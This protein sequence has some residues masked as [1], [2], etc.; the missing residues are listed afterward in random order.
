MDDDLK[1][2][3]F[4]YPS[5]YRNHAVNKFAFENIVGLQTK[6]IKFLD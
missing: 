1:G 5:L 6:Y 4:E 2:F 3:I